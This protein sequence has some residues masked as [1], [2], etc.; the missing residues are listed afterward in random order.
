MNTP[1]PNEMMMGVTVL[2]KTIVVG[3]SMPA[4]EVGGRMDVSEWR[5]RRSG[6]VLRPLPPEPVCTIVIPCLQERTYIEA[7]VRAAATQR[8]PRDRIEIFVVDGGSDDG[9][10]EIVKELAEE[11]PRIVLL[12][13]RAQLQAAGLNLGIRRA[14]GDVIVRMDAHAEYDA[15]YVSAAVTALARTGALVVGG[16]MRP[17]SHTR[18]QRALCAALSSPLG[19]GGS[20]CRDPEREGFVESVWCG[21]FRRETFELVGLFDEEARTNEDAELC[22]RILE[23][24]GRVYQSR[25]VLGHYYPRGSMGALLR[26]YFRYGLGRARTYRKRGRLPSIRPMLPFATVAMAFALLLIV[27]V[28][29]SFAPWLV[30]AASAYALVV[31]MEASRVSL[32][33]DLSIWQVPVVAAIFPA[34]HLAHGFGFGLGLLLYAKGCSGEGEPERLTAR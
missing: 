30:C 26:Q 3:C 23:R 34:M 31:V 24:G 12:D 4:R 20:P 21:A 33:Q 2:K 16:A 29:P 13:N 7:A 5:A 14:R 19:A 11:D 32:Q 22:Q 8:Y 27:L 9:T 17:R 6:V 10:R 15:G 25:A 1:R 28:F 18:F